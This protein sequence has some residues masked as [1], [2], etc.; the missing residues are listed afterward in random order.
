MD[1]SVLW[2]ETNGTVWVFRTLFSLLY[3]SFVGDIQLVF[4]FSDVP[5]CEF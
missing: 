3:Q 5:S 1:G 4:L 2:P